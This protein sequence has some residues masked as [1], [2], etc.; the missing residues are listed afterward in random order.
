MNTAR[1][2]SIESRQNNKMSQSEE[3]K[4]IQVDKNNGS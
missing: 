4:D 1:R 3:I 2:L